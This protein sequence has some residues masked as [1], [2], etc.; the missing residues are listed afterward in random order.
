MTIVFFLQK[1][2]VLSDTHLNTW[3]YNI[4]S[5]KLETKVLCLIKFGLDCF[6]DF[7]K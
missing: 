4:F 3:K 2:K 6:T 7:G 5:I 1:V